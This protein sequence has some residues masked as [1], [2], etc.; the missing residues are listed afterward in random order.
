VPAA[1]D[2]EWA[3]SDIDRFVLA[4]LEAENL[5]PVAD[6]AAMELVRRT[7]FQLVGLPP[8][9]TQ[10]QQFQEL[11]I[12]QA[13]ERLVDELLASPQFGQRWG[14]HWLDLARYADSNGLDENF[15]FREAWR[16]RNWVIDA[17]NADMPFD[18]F[19][20]EQ[21]AGDLLPYETLDQRDRQRIAAGFLVVGPKVLLGVNPDRQRMDVADEQLESISRAVL[22]QTVGCARCHDHKFDP[23]PTADYYAMAGILTS[24][25]VMEQRYMLGEQRVM[26]RLAG[27][28]E[29]GDQLNAAYETYWRERPGKNARMEKVKAFWKF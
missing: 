17:V 19:L 16:Y 11:P 5:H 20:L 13:M 26:E 25:K 29:Q 18:R 10:I 21:L 1:Q 9:E 15:L 7:S 2:H 4:K 23:I 8:T 12:P 28:G 24:T 6:A 27:L 22:A 14:R 3:R